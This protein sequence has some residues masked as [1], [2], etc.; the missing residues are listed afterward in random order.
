MFDKD[1]ALQLDRLSDTHVFK[2]RLNTKYHRN[3]YN[4]GRRASHHRKAA[5]R[6]K[7]L[8]DIASA[9][10]KLQAAV[11]AHQGFVA[12]LKH[13]REEKAALSKDPVAADI[14]PHIEDSI[15]SVD[16][17]RHD[18]WK[19]LQ[20]LRR[21]KK[22]LVIPKGLKKNSVPGKAQRGKFSIRIIPSDPQ[23][24]TAVNSRYVNQ[25]CILYL[26]PILL[27]STRACRSTISSGRISRITRPSYT[28][29]HHWHGNTASPDSIRDSN[30]WTRP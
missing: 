22:T 12:E 15:R 25:T 7:L 6:S 2:N 3:N 4:F 1:V 28:S 18:A 21:Q 30:P 11:K 10:A 8:G 27:Q 13:L 29:S 26:P 17:E 24:H 5:V 19:E 14:L 20:R 16:Q 23:S 9:D